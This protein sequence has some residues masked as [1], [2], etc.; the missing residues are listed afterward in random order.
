M[1]ASFD[2]DDGDGPGRRPQRR[3]RDGGR[4]HLQEGLCAAPRLRLPGWRHAPSCAAEPASS[5]TRPGNGGNALRLHRHVPF[6]PIYSFNPGNQFVTQRV[7]DGFPDHSAA[8]SDAR[9]QSRAAASSASIR[10]TSPGMR[11]QFNLTVEHEI[12]CGR[13]CS[14]PRTSATSAGIS[15]PRYNLNQAV[16]G[17]GR[18]QQPPAVLRRASHAGRC[19]VGRVRRHRRRITRSSSAPRSG[20]DARVQRPARRTPGAIRSTPWARAS[21]AAPTARCRR[22][23]AIASPTAA[24]R[25]STSAI[26]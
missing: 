11:E 4:Q 9:R 17:T 7:S 10:T 16:P 22:I 12:A 13:C 8:R 14:R 24:T 15:T 2:P 23:R 5:G 19:D 1:W 6:G 26:G 18:R 3:E 25:R 20:S 21:A